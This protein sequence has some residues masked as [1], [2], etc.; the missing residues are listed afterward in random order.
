MLRRE[1]SV[2][3]SILPPKIV[4]TIAI[5]IH[6][7][8]MQVYKHYE[9]KCLEKLK[10]KNMTIAKCLLLFHPYPSLHFRCPFF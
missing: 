4:S 7:F 8:E 2:L 3:Q 1:K 6:P 10:S 9:D 5:E